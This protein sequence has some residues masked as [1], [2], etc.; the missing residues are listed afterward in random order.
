LRIRGYTVLKFT[1]LDSN[2]N[3]KIRK[4][5]YAYVV[6]LDPN[7]YHTMPYSWKFLGGAEFEG[8]G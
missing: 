6:V 2:Q 1:S 8:I 7:P 4:E 3:F 5:F